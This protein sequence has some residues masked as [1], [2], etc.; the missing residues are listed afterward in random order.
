MKIIEQAMQRA[1]RELGWPV[2]DFVVEHPKDESNGDWSSNVVLVMAG[3][4]EGNPRELAEKLVTKLQCDTQL[5]SKV[6]VAKIEVAGSGFINFWLRDEYLV[7]EAEKVGRDEWERRL[8]GKK[9]I[10]EYTDPNPFKEFHIGHLMSNTIGEAIARL[11]VAEGAQVKRANY[12]GDVGMHV[13]KSVW[14]MRKKMEQEGVKLTELEE[15]PIKERQQWMGQAYA[16]GAAAY[17]EKDETKEEITQINQA[18]YTQSDPEITALYKAGREWSLS[19]FETIYARLGTKFDEYFFESEAGKVGLTVVEEGLA[20]GVLEL[21]EGEAV[22]YKGEKDGLHTRVFRNQRGLPTYE[23]KDLGLARTKYKRYPYDVS[24]IV[25]ANEIT[26]YFK[27]VLLVMSKLYPELAKK[28]VHLPHG[29]MKLPT[30]KMSSRTGKVVTGESLLDE[31]K[32]VVLKKM[33]VREIAGKEKVA[34]QVAVGALKWT[35]LKQTVGRDIVYEPAQMTNLEGETGAYVQYTYVRA[36]AVLEKVGGWEEKEGQERMQE[37]VKGLVRWLVRYPE[38]V[39]QAAEDKAPREL[40][41]YLYELAS[42]FNG[43]YNDKRIAGDKEREW[44]TGIVAKVLERGLLI[45]GIAAPEE[46]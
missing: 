19:Y 20:K 12:Q 44:V 33:G 21:G 7:S 5:S 13:A 41:G 18:V 27:V 16:L 38:T 10:V 25:T 14:G 36:R 45:L 40:A 9:V 39:I 32:T 26:E 1:V 3:K 24:Y 37:E 22:V 30:G 46:M 34:D 4:M 17:E 6:E 29:V 8:T 23:A 31:L 11:L 15:K 28:T 42:R 2:V 35:V 43:F